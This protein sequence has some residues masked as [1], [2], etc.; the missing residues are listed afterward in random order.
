M[1]VPEGARKRRRVRSRRG[2]LSTATQVC[3]GHLRYGWISLACFCVL[4][5]VLESLHGFKMEFYL[6]ERVANR[7]FCWMAAHATGTGLSLLHLV[8]AATVVHLNDWNPRSRQMISYAFYSASL[9]IPAGFLLAGCFLRDGDPGLGM[10][11]VMAACCLLMFVL[12]STAKQ[13]RNL[14]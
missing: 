5:I 7:R 13:T 6:A 11:L 3:I 14:S 4:G 8:F 10:G 12:A 1:N 9:L 2:A